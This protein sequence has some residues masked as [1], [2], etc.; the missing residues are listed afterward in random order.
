MDWTFLPS[1]SRSFMS[2]FLLHLL[3]STQTRSPLFNLP[4]SWKIADLDKQATV[5]VFE[6]ALVNPDLAHGLLFVLNRSFGDGGKA[7]VEKVGWGEREMEV[8]KRG[9]EVGK[10][11][12]ARAV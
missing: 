8:V 5:E 4:K 1:A 12:L 2:T 10:K 9:L 7:A 6:K 3:V 11:V